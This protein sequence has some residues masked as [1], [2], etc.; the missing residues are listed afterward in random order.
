MSVVS[1]VAT[2]RGVGLEGRDVPKV[3]I[4]S[5]SLPE[6]NTIKPK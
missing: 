4:P 2:I 6:R 5:G 3:V 1:P